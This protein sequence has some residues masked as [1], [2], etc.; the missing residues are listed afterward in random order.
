MTILFICL[1]YIHLPFYYTIILPQR[2]CT[3]WSSTYQAFFALW[4]MIIWS[5]IPTICMIVFGLLIIRHLHRAKLRVAPHNQLQQNRRK[6]D[7]Q[8]IQMLFLQSFVLGS[9]T[10]PLS[11]GSL[12][13]SITNSF[14]TKSDLE[15]AK[16]NYTNNVLNYIAISGPCISFYVFT[17]SS[18]TFRRELINC[19]HR[20]I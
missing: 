2:T 15:K 19:F 3:Y 6:T 9:T 14:R 12:Y 5:W 1:A 17:L 18:Q 8:L 10:I 11:I 16:D 4:N 20:Y 7:R 13:I